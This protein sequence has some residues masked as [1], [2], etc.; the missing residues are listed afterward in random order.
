MTIHN[1]TLNFSFI[2]VF[3]VDGR[4]KTCGAI[5][6]TIAPYGPEAREIVKKSGHPKKLK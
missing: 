3:E 1:F 6:Y 2:V 4:F 5:R